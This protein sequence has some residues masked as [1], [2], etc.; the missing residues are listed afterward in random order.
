MKNIYKLTFLVV[1]LSL[2]SCGN[3]DK[4]AVVD[5]ATPIAVT[6]NKVTTNGNSPFLTVS[7]KIQASNSANLSTRMMGFVNKIYINVGDKVNKGQ[8]LLTVNNTELQAKL[9]QVNASIT[10]ANAAYNNAEKD[11]NR[12]INL[13]AESSVSQKEMDDMTA[14][15]EMAKA[16]LEAANQIKNEVNAQFA[17]T[18]IKSPFAGVVTNKFIKEGDLASPGVP[19][20]AV[21]SIGKF[22]VTAM[23]P[24]SE[25]SQIK[26]GVEVV[27]N[28]KSIKETITGTVT[29]VSSSAK[30]TGGQ[31]LVKIALD[32]TDKHILSGM[33]VTVQFPVEK[34]KAKNNTVLVSTEALVHNGQLTGIYTVSQSN[35]AVLRW[36]RLGRTFGDQVEVLS[37]L[38]VDESYIVSTDG[39]L[40]NGVKISIK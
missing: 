33:F 35:T 8:L 23:V 40:Y 6:I 20:I 2:S 15:F 17:Y 22:E 21:E 14:N 36:L 32:K 26:S 7:G 30:N 5:T 1:T 28:V 25:I 24:E 9:A 29:E 34:T 39:R 37:G 10:E 13:F 16:R 31:Y 11:Y 3:E 12:F 27:V 38:N 18:N 4:T 19:L